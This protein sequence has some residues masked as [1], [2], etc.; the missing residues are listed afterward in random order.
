MPWPWIFLA[1]TLVGAFFTFN[2]YVPQRARGSLVGVSFFAGWLTDEL[3]VHHFAW[4]LGAT[5]FFVS[6]GALSAW[7]GWLGLGITL[8]SWAGLFGLA[9][10]SGRS[11]EALE[12]GLERGL[13]GGYRAAIAPALAA[14]LERPPRRRHQLSAFWMREPEVRR[15]KGI[16]YAPEHGFRG[17]L[18]VYQPRE[19][20]SGA[21]VLFQVHGGAWTISQKGHQALPLMTHLARSGWVCVAPNY[22]LSPRATW[23]DHLVDL[24]RALAWVREHIADYGGDPRF[25]AVTGGSAGGHLSAMLGLTANDPSFQP[26]FEE[27]DTRVS[28][29]VPFYGVYDF[30]DSH[31]RQLHDGLQPF[32]ARLV[33]KKSLA[34]HRRE[35]ERA[36]PLHRI[37]A[38]APPFFV[39]HGTHDSLTPVEEARLFVE[40]LAASSREPVCYAEIPGAQHAFETFHSLRTRHVVRGVERFLAWVYSREL[41]RRQ[42]PAPAARAVAT[43]PT[44]ADPPPPA[45][46]RSAPRARPRGGGG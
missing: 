46:P 31:R 30:T 27:V 8:A 6:V 23:P 40:T 9:L 37:H 7:P 16:A 42:R 43:S 26:G 44:A 28:A 15:T 29:C 2:A 45:S 34:E 11:R 20:V 18:D 19:A 10:R 41:A 13:G 14:R 21:P 25:V 4:Q 33:M 1:V 24:K 12:T 32:L 35:W 5:L 36:S 39:L 17:Q 38:D 3:S 22:R